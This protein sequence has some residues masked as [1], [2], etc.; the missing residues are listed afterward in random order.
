MEC[1]HFNALIACDTTAP[2]IAHAKHKNTSC[3]L[4]ARGT[5]LVTLG[6]LRL[7]LWLVLSSA[8]AR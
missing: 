1:C 6:M 2:P 8:R 4:G 3:I 5:Q 7:W